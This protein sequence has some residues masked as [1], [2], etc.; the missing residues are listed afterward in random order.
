LE[1]G[2]SDGIFLKF[3]ETAQID[4]PMVYTEFMRFAPEGT[5]DPESLKK[6]LVSRLKA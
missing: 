2:F 4:L 1:A 6:F 5:L 3:L